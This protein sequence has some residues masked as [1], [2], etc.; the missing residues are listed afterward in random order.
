M[1][2]FYLRYY[3]YCLLLLFL[4]LVVSSC[5]SL[6]KVKTVTIETIK[7][8]TIVKI[9]IDTIT[10]T[11]TSSITDTIKI[12]NTTSVARSYYN[13]VSNRI[14]LELTGKVFDVPVQML[15]ETKTKTKTVE[16]KSNVF[17]IGYFVG[18]FTLIICIIIY[19]KL[20]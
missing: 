10:I 12:E 6:K 5:S 17:W 16:R 2:C 3:G 18:V 8:D 9:K 19:K 4:L 7:I 15:K 11:K 14:V 13:P 20:T 1:I